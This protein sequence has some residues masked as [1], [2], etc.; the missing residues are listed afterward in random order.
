MPWLRDK[1]CFLMYCIKAS[2]DHLPINI[3]VYT[4]V[5]ARNTPIAPPERFE[6]VPTSSGRNPKTSCPKLATA[7]QIF[8]RIINDGIENPFPSN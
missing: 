8:T 6:W 3:M 4:G 1:T 7:L 5:P 2:E